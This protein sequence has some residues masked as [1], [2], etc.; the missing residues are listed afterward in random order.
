VANTAAPPSNPSNG[1]HG[2]GAAPIPGAAAATTVFVPG[3]VVTMF[4]TIAGGTTSVFVPFT[5]AGFAGIG[6]SF[7]TGICVCGCAR[8]CGS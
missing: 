2:T 5:T 7:L 4:E 3:T 1:S 8:F 6:D